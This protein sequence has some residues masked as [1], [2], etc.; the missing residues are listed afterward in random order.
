MFLS[1]NELES[2]M[3]LQVGVMNGDTWIYT[4]NRIESSGQ[5]VDKA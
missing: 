4:E 2:F 3:S 5:E 1:C